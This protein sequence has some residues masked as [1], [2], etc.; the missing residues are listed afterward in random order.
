MVRPVSRRAPRIRETPCRT[1]IPP[2]SNIC[3]SAGNAPTPIASPRPARPRRRCRAIGIR[4][5]RSRGK[6]RRRDPGFR[7]DRPGWHDYRRG[8]T[9]AC[10]AELRCS[11]EEMADQLARFSLPGRDPSLPI[12]D[13]G[14]YP[15]HIPGTNIYAGDV[16]TRIT[17]GGLTIENRTKEGHIFFDGIVVRELKQSGDGAWYVTTHGFGNNVQPGSNVVNQLVGP[18]TFAELD[19]QM[20]ANIERHH[21]K[22]I[23]D[24][25]VH[26]VDGGRRPRSCHLG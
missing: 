21:A 18:E 8:P 20:R 4:G 5:R 14:T 26:R 25:A 11:R 2:R 12:E 1:C 6:S 15:V 3:A 13:E 22:G 17:D 16:E 23:L 24:L 9:L 10:G 7:S 19:R